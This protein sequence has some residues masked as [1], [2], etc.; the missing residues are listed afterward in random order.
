MSVKATRLLRIYSRLRR[1]PVTIDIIKDWARKNSIAISERTLYRDLNDIENSIMLEGEKI[2]VCEGEKNKKT[3]KIEF[4]YSHNNLTE[5]DINSFHLFKNFAPLSLVS[6]R[7]S[8]LEKM[9]NLFYSLNSK[10]KFENYTTAAGLQI[11]ASH[12]YEFPYSEGYN[13]ILQDCIWSIQNQRQLRLDKIDFDYTSISSSIR[14]PLVLS[15]VQILYHRGCIHLAGIVEETR[16]IIL[17]LEQIK[18]YELT[19]NMFDASELVN[20]FSEQMDKRF[21]IS[22][23]IDPEVYEIEIEF[24]EYTGSFVSHHFWHASQ[25]FHQRADG[26]YLL[27]LNCG[28]NRELIGWILQWM[29]NARVI[30]PLLLKN[31]VT[32]KLEHISALYISQKS[33]VSNNCFKPQ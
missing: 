3:W 12:F 13:K 32:E 26:N 23:N 24:S 6:S 9:E 19:N 28:I 2:V 18:T 17:A 11:S 10:S 30:K 20:L 4:N 8:S 7:S 33:L 5:F 14:F 16:L 22:E 25:K 15:P 27:T 29:S 31:L 1:G 21:G